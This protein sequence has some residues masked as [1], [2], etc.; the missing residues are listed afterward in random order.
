LTDQPIVP[1]TNFGLVVEVVSLV[2][3]HHVLLVLV[4]LTES[5]Y[6]FTAPNF[7]SCMARLTPPPYASQS[8]PAPSF[9]LGEC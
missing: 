6:L 1:G 3:S 2:N 7:V 4:L 8:T 5:K 9:S